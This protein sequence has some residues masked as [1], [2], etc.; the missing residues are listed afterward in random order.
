MCACIYRKQSPQ[1]A[2]T[3]TVDTPQSRLLAHTCVYMYMHIMYIHMH[4][5]SIYMYMY[6]SVSTYV[7]ICMQVC[8]DIHSSRRSRIS[9]GAAAA[10]HAISCGGCG[11][12]LLYDLYI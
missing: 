3:S 4:T 6:I 7:C 9:C 10:Y 5:T 2:I 8:M 12:Y 1:P 11:V